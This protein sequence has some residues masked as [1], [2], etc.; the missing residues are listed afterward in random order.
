MHT[1]AHTHTRGSDPKAASDP[2]P[3]SD[4]SRST[5]ATSPGTKTHNR[6]RAAQEP[7]GHHGRTLTTRNRPQRPVRAPQPR[8]RAC[9]AATHTSQGA[10]HARSHP[11]PARSSTPKRHPK[12]RPGPVQPQTKP[13]KRPTPLE[14]THPPLKNRAEMGAALRHHLAG[15]IGIYT[16]RHHLTLDPATRLN[17]SGDW[18]RP[19]RLVRQYGPDGAGA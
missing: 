12:P 14:K 2:L 1:L 11:K 13:R 19:S 6:A 17:G 9:P 15:S 5:A 4:P 16:R 10:T 8:E 3:E 7:P 18:N